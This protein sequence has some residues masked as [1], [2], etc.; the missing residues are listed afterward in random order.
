MYGEME[1]AGEFLDLSSDPDPT[2]GSRGAAKS[3]RFLGIQFACCSIYSRVYVNKEGTA[4]VGNCP[5]C[6]KRVELKIGPGGSDSRFFTA[7]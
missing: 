7:Y 4:Y 1:M 2:T 6:T 5:K 3:R